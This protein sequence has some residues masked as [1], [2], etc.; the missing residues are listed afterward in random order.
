MLL[1]RYYG[2]RETFWSR[3]YKE[4]KIGLSA[5]KLFKPNGYMVT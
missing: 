5:H 3:S 4:E 1:Y 2:N